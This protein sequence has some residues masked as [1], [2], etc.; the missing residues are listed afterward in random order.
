MSLQQQSVRA[1]TAEQLECRT[2]IK[3]HIATSLSIGMDDFELAPFYEKGGAIKAYHVF[4]QELDK[5][6]EELN[7]VLVV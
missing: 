2:M 6:L 5:V 1:F 4:G 7:E 3:N